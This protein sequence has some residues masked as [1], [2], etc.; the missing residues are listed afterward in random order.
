MSITAA[1]PSQKKGAYAD[2]ATSITLAYTNN[3]AAGNL[4][5]IGTADIGTHVLVVGDISKSAGSATLGAFALDKQIRDANWYIQ[6]AAFSAIVTGGGSCTIRVQNFSAGDYILIGLEE[7]HS[8]AGGFDASRKESSNSAIGT[9]NPA[10]SGN[11]SSAG[12]ACFYGALGFWPNA[13]VTITP[14]AAFTQI[15]EQESDSHCE[16]SYME[17]IVSGA[18]TDSASWSVSPAF[19]WAAVVVVYKEAAGG[20]QTFY[21]TPSGAMA[22][23][24][25]LNRQ[26]QRKWAG[27][28]ASAGAVIK[29]MA[30]AKTGAMAS[31]GTLIRSLARSLAGAMAASGALSLVKTKLISLAG[32]MASTG[33]L[34][35]Q[36]IKSLAGSMA[37]AG[38]LTRNLA[39]SLAGN[40]AA[41]GS[42]SL[43]KT[44][45][46]SLTG[47]MAATGAS[48]RKQIKSLVGSMASGGTL[49][50]SLARSLAGSMAGSGGLSLVKTKLISLA[51]SMASA[52]ALIRKE[53]KSL[54]GSMASSGALLRSAWLG[55]AGQMSSAGALQKQTA[56]G[57]AGILTSSGNLAI[58]KVLLRA[59]S[60]AMA[61]SGSLSRA[62]SKSLAG[63]ANFSGA[64]TKA[65]SR[66]FSGIMAATGMVMNFLTGYVIH[67]FITRF[68]PA[69]HKI[70]FSPKHP[71]ID[72]PKRDKEK[73]SPGR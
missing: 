46:I 33:A 24:G 71:E 67:P 10:D 6:A 32:S 23:T 15:Y 18:T 29:Q 54:A 41:T 62:I 37:S 20:P 9:A 47:S 43:V 3:V 58:A 27:S 14:D 16:G 19:H 25:A 1:S 17:R 49:I 7:F 13:A 70:C 63:S 28:C 26:P 39:R 22:A 72:S 5:A 69:R 64:V 4:L 53:I 35:R 42:L 30:F 31:A 21:I 65:L 52:G 56:K 73:E 34:I 51:G 55:K 50:R 2:D 61:A 66:S 45:L 68:S 11:A 57:F 40:M 44:K 12:G 36:Q 48:V 59:F 60:G 38:A 8:D